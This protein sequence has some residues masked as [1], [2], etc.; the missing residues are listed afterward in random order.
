M[1]MSFPDMESLQFRAKQRNFRQPNE[2]ESESEYREAF[3]NFMVDVD[4]VESAE[5]RSGLGW[6]KHEPRALLESMFP[7]MLESIGR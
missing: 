4:R 6:D 5:I 1:P 7:G 3:A 2:G